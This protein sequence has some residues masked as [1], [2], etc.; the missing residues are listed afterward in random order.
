MAF[1]DDTAGSFPEEWRN[2]AFLANPITSM[3][4]AVKINRNADGS[5]EAKLLPD[6]L[7]STDD[8]FRP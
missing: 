4:N 8:W 6:F 3:V 1:A 2:V 7:T 5:V